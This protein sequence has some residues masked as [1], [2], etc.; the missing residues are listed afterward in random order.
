MSEGLQGFSAGVLVGI[1]IGAIWIALVS[2]HD[3]ALVKRGI[4]QYNQETGVLEWVE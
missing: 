1:F 4:K 3:S 2:E